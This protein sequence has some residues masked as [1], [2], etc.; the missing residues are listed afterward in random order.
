MTGFDITQAATSYA[1][2]AGILAGFT[3]MVLAWMVE[4]LII[5]EGV[6]AKND[7]RDKDTRDKLTKQALVFLAVTFIGNVMVAI[8]WGLVS[9]EVYKDSNRPEILD[10][11]ASFDFTLITALTFEAMG[12]L[13]ALTKIPDI[14]QLFRKIFLTTVAVAVFYLWLTT[15]DVLVSQERSDILSVL[16]RHLL[17]F[18]LLI[19]LT[20]VPLLIGWGINKRWG[21][22]RRVIKHLY[23]IVAANFNMFVLALLF[24]MLLTAIGF[25]VVEDLAPDIYLPLGVAMLINFLWAILMGWAITFLP[26]NP[27][28][29]DRKHTQKSMSDSL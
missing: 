15:A 22:N 8:L 3:F 11:I 4:H 26:S 18:I 23:D 5:P 21:I 6:Q 24:V 20:F 13:V 29:D 17:F 27:N 10:L 12:F 25:G 1:Q 14:I 28:T 16:Q 9:G 2:I 19:I 7:R